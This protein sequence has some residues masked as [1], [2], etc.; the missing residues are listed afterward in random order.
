MLQHWETQDLSAQW[1][2]SSWN[3]WA[4]CWP[5]S[6]WDRMNSQ[7][8]PSSGQ[9][10][11]RWLSSSSGTWR[12]LWCLLRAARAPLICSLTRRF[13]LYAHLTRFLLQPHISAPSASPR[14]ARTAIIL[15]RKKIIGPLSSHPERIFTHA[16]FFFFH[17][18]PSVS[19]G[20]VIILKSAT[21]KFR[22]L[23][24]A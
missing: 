5:F 9:G 10:T 11:Q 7:N 21:L 3:K 18:V 19:K 6:D 2:V 20:I 12:S 17:A 13:C 16:D 14:C 24:G 4:V 1:S 22:A 8:Y 23:E 15:K